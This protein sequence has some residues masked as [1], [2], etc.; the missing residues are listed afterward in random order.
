VHNRRY[1][2]SPLGRKTRRRLERNPFTRMRKAVRTNMHKNTDSWPTPGLSITVYV[3]WTFDQLVAHL[4]KL[5][6]N[7]MT[8]QNYGKKWHVDHIRP[9]YE[10]NLTDP[11]CEDFKKC[12][13]LSNLQ[14][15]WAH[16]NLIKGKSAFVN[17]YFDE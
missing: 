2:Q 13:A 10:F 16:Q 17:R 7:G 8:W 4:E 14:P 9:Q 1:G 12:W 11:Y 5:F 15:L 6:V 3:D